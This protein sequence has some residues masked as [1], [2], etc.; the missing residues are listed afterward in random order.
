MPEPMISDKTLDRLAGNVVTYWTAV[1]VSKL[2]LIPLLLVGVLLLPFAKERKSRIIL[3]RKA[4][5]SLFYAW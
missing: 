3:I 4:T 1:I 5:R 2:I